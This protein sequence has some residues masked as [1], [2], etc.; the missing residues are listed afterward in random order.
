MTWCYTLISCHKLGNGKILLPTGTGSILRSTCNRI[1]GSQDPPAKGAPISA[2][3]HQ[4]RHRSGR[5]KQTNKHDIDVLQGRGRHEVPRDWDKSISRMF[6]KMQSVFPRR[7]MGPILGWL[8]TIFFV[9][10]LTS[11]EVFYD[12]WLHPKYCVRQTWKRTKSVKVFPSNQRKKGKKEACKACGKPSEAAGCLNHFTGPIDLRWVVA[13]WMLP[14]CSASGT[15][16]VVSPSEWLRGPG[17]EVVHSCALAWSKVPKAF[18]TLPKS[19]K[20]HHPLCFM[21]AKRWL[22]TAERPLILD[23]SILQDVV[24]WRAIWIHLTKTEWQVLECKKRKRRS[25]RYKK[26]CDHIWPLF[27]ENN[28]PESRISYWVGL[29]RWLLYVL[30][31]SGFLGWPCVTTWGLTDWGVDPITKGGLRGFGWWI[32]KGR[33]KTLETTEKHRESQMKKALYVLTQMILQS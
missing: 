28:N 22:L 27:F 23:G 10:G 1:Q 19:S 24:N 20:N 14:S 33:K 11:L 31:R 18:K 29:R 25:L 4:P 8:A 3:N 9:W 16:R 12:F 21:K 7:W 26:I 15:W 17:R 6:G 30:W 13:F 32:G 5:K 2:P